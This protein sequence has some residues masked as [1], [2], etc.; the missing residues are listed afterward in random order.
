MLYCAAVFFIMALIAA[1]LGFGGIAAV[2]LAEI[3]KL[4][5]FIFLVAF[6]VSLLM[7]VFR[8]DV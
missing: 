2:G 3:A 1:V 4:L 7:G 6:V 5:F 8:S